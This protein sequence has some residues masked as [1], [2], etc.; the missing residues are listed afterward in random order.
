[1]QT[2]NLKIKKNLTYEEIGKQLDISPQ[3]VHKI[4]KEAI[5][6]VF[7]R[8]NDCTNFNPVQVMIG[9]CEEF[10]VNPEQI[11]KKLDDGNKN[12]L[13]R[14]IQVEYDKKIPGL[15]TEDIESIEDLFGV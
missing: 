5:N 9:V 10:N 6:K 11:F 15:E 8:L 7:K 2:K 1:M 4:E 12:V 13:L 3:Q 14:F